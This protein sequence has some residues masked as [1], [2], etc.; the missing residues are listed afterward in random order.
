V[1]YSGRE[2]R[3]TSQVGSDGKRMNSRLL[4]VV[5]RFGN[6]FV[7]GAEKLVH[8]LVTRGLPDGWKADVATTCAVDHETWENVLAPGVEH[9]N[10]VTVH[11]FRVGRRDADLYARL[12]PRILSGE[13]DYAEELAWLGASVWAPDLLRFLQA[14]SSGY[15]V[16][17]FSPYFFGT[18]IWGAQVAPEQSALMP[19]LHDEPYARLET[20]RRIMRSVRGCIFNTDAEERLARSLY[21]VE[22]GRVVGMGYDPPAQPPDASF[23]EPRGLGTYVLYAGRLEEGKRVHV[24]VDYALRYAAERDNAPKLVLLGLGSYEVPEEAGEIV[25]RAGFVSEEEK[26]A[27]YAGA[28]AVVNP[29]HMESLSLVLMEAWLEGA[30]A[31]V[32]EGSAVLREHA[33][34]SAGALTFDSYESYRDAL[35]RLRDED[36]LRER[37]ATAGREYVVDT[38]AWPVVRR[39][40]SEALEALTP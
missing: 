36:G 17:F 27:A 24:A 40:F 12:H 23:A 14:E 4:W 38:Y 21:D 29:S 34:R 6:Q 8:G 28:L 30:P 1:N 11:R 39:R 35:D 5:P 15:G 20:V 37:L 33:D 32:D 26:R 2:D 13:A 7:G 22:V 31:L 18:T 10:G 3:G 9:E 16:V 19:C 25:L